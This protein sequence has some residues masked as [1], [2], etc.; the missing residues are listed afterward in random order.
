M[1]SRAALACC[2]LLCLIGC[3]ADRDPNK[4]RNFKTNRGQGAAVELGTQKLRRI[5]RNAA[6]NGNIT[7]LAAFLDQDPDVVGLQSF[8]TSNMHVLLLVCGTMLCITDMQRLGCS[9]Y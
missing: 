3:L 8:S 7:E 1:G 2:L 6:F 5:K 4:W 9:S